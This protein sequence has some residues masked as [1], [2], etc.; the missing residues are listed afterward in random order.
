MFSRGYHLK[1]HTDGVHRNPPGPGGVLM[2]GGSF[3]PQSPGGTAA[4]LTIDSVA[5]FGRKSAI[6]KIKVYCSPQK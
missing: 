4:N 5:P 3:T 2:T 6:K 1:R